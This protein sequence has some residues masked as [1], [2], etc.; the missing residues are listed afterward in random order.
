MYI[1]L[2]TYALVRADYDYAE[3]K[4]G[5][6]IHLLGIGYTENQSS[7]SIY[8]I[9]KDDNYLLKYFSKKFGVNFSFDRSVA[10]IK[11]RK[12]FLFD[13]KLNE[14]K[15]AFNI[16][17]NVEESIEYLVLDFKEISHEQFVD[18]EQKKSMQIISVD[19]FDNEL[20]KGYP[21]IRTHPTNAGV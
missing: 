21:I 19:K 5:R 12:R 2:N 9:K 10:L 15:V 13:K 11:K 20:W 6:D 4:T 3:G 17:A 1:A 16:S 7:G 14:I 18:F 8:F